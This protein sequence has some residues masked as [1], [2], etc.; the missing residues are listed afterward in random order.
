MGGCKLRSFT[1]AVYR[2]CVVKRG[3]VQEVGVEKVV[4]Q[5]RC[6]EKRVLQKRCCKKGVLC[7]RVFCTKRELYKRIFLDIRLY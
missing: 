1:R 5:K 2:R 7:N 4:V 6:C 3:V